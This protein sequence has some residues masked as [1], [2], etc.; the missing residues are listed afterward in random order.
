[1][2]SPTNDSKYT[3]PTIGHSFLT[4]CQTDPHELLDRDVAG[5]LGRI[6][7]H[8]P[9]QLQAEDAPCRIIEIDVVDLALVVTGL[10]EHACPEQGLVAGH[11]RPDRGTGS[12][13]SR[14]RGAR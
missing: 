3:S 5:P 8:P 11:D 4:P 9:G 13:R 6:G 2:Q 1:M 7:E 14:S 12:L 10:G